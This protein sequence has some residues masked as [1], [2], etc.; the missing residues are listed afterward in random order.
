MFTTT[1]LARQLY[2]ILPFRISI[3]KGSNSHSAYKIKTGS[4]NR[5]QS[6]RKETRCSMYETETLIGRVFRYELVRCKTSITLER[7]GEVI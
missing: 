3:E 6:C 7:A 1:I 5:K 2:K 4:D